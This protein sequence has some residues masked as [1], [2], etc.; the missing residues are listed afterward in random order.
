MTT[1]Y[2]NQSSTIDNTK[3][4]EQIFESPIYTSLSRPELSIFS[5]LFNQHKDYF[6]G[7][8]GYQ[9]QV[10]SNPKLIKLEREKKR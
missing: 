6:S 7:V 5:D 9:I 2:Y 10:D 1:S 4:K 8:I 3:P